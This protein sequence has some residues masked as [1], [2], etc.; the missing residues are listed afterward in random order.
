MAPLLEEEAFAPTRTPTS[1]RSSG[2]TAPGARQSVVTEG[3]AAEEMR[4]IAREISGRRRWLMLGV[5]GLVVLLGV[6]GV[7]FV[8]GRTESGPERGPSSPPVATVPPL[9]TQPVT[10]PVS[11]SAA[12]ARL[13]A[14]PPPPPA[15]T[16]P[17]PPGFLVVKAQPWGKLY[18]DGK[19]AGDVEGSRRFPLAPGSHIL[20]LVNGKKTFPWTVEVESGKT[21][22][23]EHS[24][25]EE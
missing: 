24:F 2:A 8:A 12:E 13:P 5:V 10:R 17:A 15:L 7:A 14:P 22:T 23:R 9:P 4:A 16:P 3:G 20:R 18:V 6:G 11:P 19:F 25:L 21:V 1:R